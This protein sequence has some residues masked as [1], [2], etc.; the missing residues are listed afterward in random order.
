MLCCISENMVAILLTET[1]PSIDGVARL[2]WHGKAYII[3]SMLSKGGRLMSKYKCGYPEWETE[4]RPCDN[5]N[6]QPPVECA[7]CC[8]GREKA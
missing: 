6:E 8:W 5:P 1:T 2:G 7:E 4:P 3:M